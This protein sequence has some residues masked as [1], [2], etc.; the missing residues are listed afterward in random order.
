MT[1]VTQELIKQ[2][3]ESNGLSPDELGKAFN[4]VKA[5]GKAKAFK[6]G[7]I[8]LSADEVALGTAISSLL[9]AGV[10]KAPEAKVLFYLINQGEIKNSKASEK[11]ESTPYSS[12]SLIAEIGNNANFF[13]LAPAKSDKYVVTKATLWGSDELKKRFYVGT[14]TRNGRNLS[15][16]NIEK[17]PKA[18]DTEAALNE[19]NLTDFVV[20]QKF[21]KQTVE[22]KDNKGS[23][24]KRSFNLLVLE[25]SGES[26]I[27]LYVETTNRE[28]VDA[29]DTSGVFRGI[30]KE[31]TYTWKGE[32]RMRHKL[33]TFPMASTK[34]WT[35]EGIK[36]I[37]IL[38]DFSNMAPYLRKIVLLVP[39]FGDSEVSIKTN[40]DTK[41]R[42]AF[43]S[44][45]DMNGTSLRMVAFD[46]TPLEKVIDDD[47]KLPYLSR[48]L[49]VVMENPSKTEINLQL[50]AIEPIGGDAGI[51]TPKEEVSK[52]I[53][54][55]TTSKKVPVDS[56]GDTF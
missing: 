8:D 49:G 38:S 53:T 3:A 50:L 15:I 25:P 7:D 41:N 24:D 32:E 10:G 2:K 47:D 5:T 11:K 17:S 14:L 55:N 36:D 42:T 6:Y 48:V 19:M 28:W 31:E 37:P 43:G 4:D 12:I 35:L 27:L 45:A 1:K 51:L 44:V 46:P 20:L 29:E 16:A 13:A 23:F 33:L 54:E 9:G 30:L 40:P 22:L 34:T 39:A 18:F 52:K 56:D 26:R 21:P